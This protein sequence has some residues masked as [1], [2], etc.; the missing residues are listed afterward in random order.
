[1]DVKQKKMKKLFVFL[2]ALIGMGISVNAGPYC[3]INGA[4][5]TVTAENLEVQDNTAAD[6]YTTKEGYVSFYLSNSSDNKK[7]HVTYSVSIRGNI[8]RSESFQL[9]PE[10]K[11]MYITFKINTTDTPIGNSDVVIDISGA[12][13]VPD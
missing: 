8:I 2:V 4:Y 5:G 10:G 7:V 3:K 12:D 6:Y 11:Q 9:Q 1:M 13:C